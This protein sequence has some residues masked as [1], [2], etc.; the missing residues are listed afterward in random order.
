[1]TQL[2]S[3]VKEYEDK[4]NNIMPREPFILDADIHFEEYRIAV[5]EWRKLFLEWL[6]SELFT[7]RQDFERQEQICEDTMNELYKLR[8]AY[9]MLLPNP[10]E[11]TQDDS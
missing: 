11:V 9:E 4:T 10:E 7:L 5:V 3:L 1:M 6:S 2:E 8:D